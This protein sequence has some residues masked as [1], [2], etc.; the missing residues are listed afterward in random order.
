ML[1]PQ[2]SADF[3]KSYC[4]RPDKC[5]TPDAANAKQR[6]NILTFENKL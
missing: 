4:G 2:S 5:E 1:S 6:D 3:G